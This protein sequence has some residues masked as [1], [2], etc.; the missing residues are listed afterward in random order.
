MHKMYTSDEN[1][2][3]T[4][5]DP[6]GSG[7]LKPF[8]ALCSGKG[9][10]NAWWLAFKHFNLWGQ[11]LYIVQILPIR[12]D[13]ISCVA[14]LVMSSMWGFKFVGEIPRNRQT[15]IPDEQ[16][17]CYSMMIFFVLKWEWKLPMAYMVVLLRI[18]CFFWHAYEGCQPPD[19]TG[20]LCP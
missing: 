12:G 7:P 10:N 15:L 18:L 2:E 16:K 14:G 1:E 19:I 11:C 3:K 9:E 20:Y 8:Q 6:D 5:I 4:F 17:R 13:L